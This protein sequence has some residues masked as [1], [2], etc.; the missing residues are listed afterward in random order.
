GRLRL[1]K[2]QGVAAA[3]D[4]ARGIVVGRELAG[5]GVGRP[6]PVL[7]VCKGAI[8][9]P[10][11]LVESPAIEDLDDQ[12]DVARIEEPEEAGGVG[13]GESG[14]V[15][16]LLVVLVVPARLHPEAAAG[17]AEGARA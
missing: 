2:G 16:E 8:E 14:A 6:E 12:L 1:G 7:D 17:E 3:A 11:A 15:A 13:E 9:E 10:E 4:P 5:R